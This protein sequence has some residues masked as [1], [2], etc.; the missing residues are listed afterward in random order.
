MI[1]ILDAIEKIKEQHFT[2]VKKEECREPPL[3]L[4]SVTDGTV[5]SISQLFEVGL[6]QGGPVLSFLAPWIY[7]YLVGGVKTILLYYKN[8]KIS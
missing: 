6:C 4:V 2:A 5:R 7:Y 8:L 3:G 1:C